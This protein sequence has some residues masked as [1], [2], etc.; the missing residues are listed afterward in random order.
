MKED[1]EILRERMV[2]EQL[3]P[4]GIHAE[5]VLQAFRRVPRHFFVPSNQLSMAYGD[6]PLGIGHGQTIS[7]PYIVA[8]M[9]E[10]L[11]LEANHKVL[12]IGTGSG[13]QTAI[14]AEIAKD[15]YT[16]ERVKH[17]HEQAKEILGKLNYTNV[18]FLWGDGHH[19]WPEKAPFNG[20]LVTAAAAHFLPQL[21]EQ[22][23]E[24]GRMVVP[25][26]KAFT[27]ELKL[28]I[29]KGNSFEEKSLGG[30]RFVPLL[31]GEPEDVD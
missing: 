22:L 23:V 18:H 1:F 30:C 3:I 15:I 16:V 4:R 6:H 19:G 25:V 8:L 29:K 17:L 12:E 7:Q 26:G 21:L 10:A 28:L 2:K 20:V 31:E 24:G 9:T 14:L 11:A 13:Y 27:Q 5:N